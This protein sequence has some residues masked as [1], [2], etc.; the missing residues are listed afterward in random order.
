MNTP[1]GNIRQEINLYQPQLRPTLDILSVKNTLFMLAIFMVVMVLLS[2]AG[3]VQNQNLKEQKVL[4]QKNKNELEQR[5]TKM[6]ALVTKSNS[7][8]LGKK[9][10]K[11]SS[12]IEHRK[13][14]KRVLDV[15]NV[16][17][18][19]GFSEHL[20]V[21]SQ[22]SSKHIALT[23]FG[24]SQGGKRVQLSG[25]TNKAETIPEYIEKLQTSDVFSAS[26]FGTMVIENQVIETQ[27]SEGKSNLLSFSLNQ[28]LRYSAGVDHE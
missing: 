4:L 14:L 8:A 9:I 18:A 25:V 12:Q 21:L 27:S 16:G 10:E 7:A 13:R 19:K 20:R 17:N 3:T 5:V 2:V 11:I 28:G 6:A 24:F 26:V 23:D 15:Q 22:Y 1:I